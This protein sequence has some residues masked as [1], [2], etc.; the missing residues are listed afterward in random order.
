MK[1]LLPLTAFALSAS[2]A[3]PVSASEIESQKPIVFGETFELYSPDLDEVR[4]INVRL[5]ASFTKNSDRKYPVL[6]LLDGGVAQ[7]FPHIAGLMQHG[8]ISGTFD[9]FIVVG[10]KSEKRAY[11][12]TFPASDERYTEYQKPNGGSDKMRLFL[13]NTVKRWVES[14]YQTD[15]RDV[16]MGE[17]LA[18]LF[19]V[20]T[21][22]KSPDMFD[23]Y[24]AISPS[25]WWN[26]E[27][28]PGQTAALLDKFD[29]GSKPRLYLTMANEGGTMRRGL[30]TTLDALKTGGIGKVETYFADRS[31][32]ED[33]GSIYHIAALDAFRTLYGKPHRTGIPGY[34]PWLAIGELPPLSDMAK[35]NVEK[36]CTRE[37]AVR[38][39]YV[40]IGADPAKWRGVCVLPV[41]TEPLK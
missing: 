21:M 11:E 33:H 22:L 10:I 34:A 25:L 14:Y 7:D 32:S 19:V 18:A 38:T 3:L 28:L 30:D 4:E 26:R 27:E 41:T 13:K 37:N 1:F 35:E 2:I 40:E 16:L 24:I 31:Q 39:T 6:Y 20:E 15:G 17:S 23:D 12:L 9:E 36:E 29:S 5:P 8:E